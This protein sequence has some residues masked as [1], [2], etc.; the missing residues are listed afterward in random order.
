MMEFLRGLAP[1][2]ANDAARAVAVLPSR[3]E[4]VWPLRATPAPP[5]ST[6]VEPAAAAL[7]AIGIASATASISPAADSVAERPVP[8]PTRRTHGGHVE[9]T[10]L[11]S[12]ARAVLGPPADSPHP[13]RARPSRPVDSALPRHAARF[14][15]TLGV[16]RS[17]SRTASVRATDSPAAPVAAGLPVAPRHAPLSANALAGRTT[18]GSERRPV[19]HVT[20]DRI[21]VRVPASPDRPKPSPRSRAAPPS[22]SLTDY[23]RPRESGRRGGAS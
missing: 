11:P 17:T 22:V 8:T 10:T 7:P 1:Q 14:A 19:I 23:L 9:S 21:D 20:I 12:V 2:P 16:S 5:A 6:R 13:E 15:S 3:F 18:Q 4:S